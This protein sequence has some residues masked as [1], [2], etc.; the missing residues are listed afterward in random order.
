MRSI[1]GLVVSACIWLAEARPTPYFLDE[2]YDPRI[3]PESLKPDRFGRDPNPDYVSHVKLQRSLFEPGYVAQHA[4]SRVVQASD[5]WNTSSIRGAHYIPS[6]AR[7][8]IGTWAN[9]SEEVMRKEIGYA[10]AANLNAI[11][12]TLHW[13]PFAVDPIAFLHQLEKTASMT[14][15]VGCRL[16][17]VLF[18]DMGSGDA[19][20]TWVTGRD[21]KY[22]HAGW[23]SN[24]GERLKRNSSQWG[25]L[26]RYIDAVLDKFREDPRVLGWDLL[27]SAS[28][29]DPMTLAFVRHVSERVMAAKPSSWQFTTVS[30]IPASWWSDPSKGGAIKP[31]VDVLSMQ[32]LN[33]NLGAVMSDVR[34]A[35]A[36]E[37]PLIITAGP[38]RPDELVCEFLFEVW[39]EISTPVLT[40]THPHIGFFLQHLVLG[41]NEFSQGTPPAQGLVHPNGTWFDPTE[42]TCVAAAV[43]PEPKLPPG[44]PDPLKTFVTPGGLRASIRAGSRTIQNLSYTGHDTSM[45]FNNFSFVP[46]LWGWT[47]R[48]TNRSHA[49]AHA[50]GDITLRLQPTSATTSNGWATYSTSR[51]SGETD[52]SLLPIPL[53][54][55][56]SR[57][58]PSSR[59]YDESDVT[60]CFSA[61]GQIDTRFAPGVQVVRSFESV[62]AASGSTD[63]FVMRFT[64]T[65]NSSN[66]EGVRL[67]G[68]GM[69]L[70]ADT[71]Y[72]G[73]N[74]QEV[75]S[76]LSFNDGHAGLDH[77]CNLLAIASPPILTFPM[78][79]S[80][81]LTLFH[82]LAHTQVC[83]VVSRRWQPV[84]CGHALHSACGEWG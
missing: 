7:N 63:G 18:D 68:L 75:A 38:H 43:P 49:G 46:P 4:A 48:K 9:F 51:C 53:T 81:I 64:I 39:G 12:L 40:A 8:S 82:A 2:S 79:F 32:N 52:P 23:T 54:G 44:P 73:L 60:P 66:K 5:P 57:E 25:V 20:P 76:T 83:H 24:P 59:A 56:S 41:R 58:L 35:L 29:G 11:R 67:G 34:S 69:S 27:N 77:G 22:E 37:M 10:K 15:A 14:A 70:P 74:T 26:D 45:F 78:T 3:R 71:T 47:P 13:V 16:L 19:D 28:L 61:P 21:K 42:R 30:L 80:P 55:R 50:V 6:H 31:I 84:P 72:G 36:N 17:L 65:A 1:S 62:D 33:G